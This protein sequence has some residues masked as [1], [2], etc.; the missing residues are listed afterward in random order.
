MCLRLAFHDFGPYKDADGLGGTNASIQY[1]L[2]R[3]ENFGLNRG[4]CAACDANALAA[5]EAATT[6]SLLRRLLPAP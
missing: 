6:V 2:K 5:V 4:W 3:P 1:E